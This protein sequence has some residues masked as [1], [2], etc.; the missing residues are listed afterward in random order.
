[1]AADSDET[2]MAQVRALMDDLHQGLLARARKAEADLAEWKAN[3]LAKDS[4]L[5][6]IRAK[7][8][9]LVAKLKEWVGTEGSVATLQ[10]PASA[11]ETPPPPT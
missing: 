1:M 6:E 7:Y 3:A 5:S 2:K 10:T 11:P 8:D 9:A 4:L